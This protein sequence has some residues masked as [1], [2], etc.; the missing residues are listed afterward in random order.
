MRNTS[1]LFVVVATLLALTTP[2]ANA[3]V[4]FG[5]TDY[6]VDF[7]DNLG[8]YLDFVDEYFDET[9]KGLRLQ[10]D[11][12][13][14]RSDQQPYLPYEDPAFSGR[15]LRMYMYRH[16][17]VGQYPVE[18]DFEVEE[19]MKWILSNGQAG[20][21]Q[22]EFSSRAYVLSN[23]IFNEMA[24]IEPLLLETINPAD[25]QLDGFGIVASDQELEVENYILG[26]GQDYYMVYE[27]SVYVRHDTLTDDPAAML[28]L[29]GGSF[30]GHDGVELTL[31]SSV[32]APEPS[33]FAMAGIGVA[34]LGWYGWR[35]KRRFP[36]SAS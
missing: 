31:N 32:I 34:S 35:R 28:T 20:N 24:V 12:F 16:F 25:A 23:T 9:S 30:S 22:F 21:P 1:L 33:S 19:D 5:Y 11:A 29:Q 18:V 26:P 7:D 6:Y 36:S 2:A 17:Q 13:L 10:A 27:T 3:Q 4:N 15:L 14:V 8:Y